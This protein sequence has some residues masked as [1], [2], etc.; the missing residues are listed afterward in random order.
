MAW[1]PL[2]ITD[3]QVPTVVVYLDVVWVGVSGDAPHMFQT[4]VLL[5]HVEH[6]DVTPH[7]L[8]HIE[9]SSV[10]RD[11]QPI[12]VVQSLPHNLSQIIS[13]TT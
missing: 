8:R 4:L 10:P 5:T 2:S 12:R 1:S 7:E 13:N 6:L 3:P 11:G 9:V